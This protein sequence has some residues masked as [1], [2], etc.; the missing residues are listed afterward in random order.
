MFFCFACFQVVESLRPRW[1]FASGYDNDSEGGRHD[2]GR[3]PFSSPEYWS[4]ENDDQESGVEEEEEPVLIVLEEK[5]EAAPIIEAGTEKKKREQQHEKDKK[6]TDA[7]EDESDDGVDSAGAE[8]G[9]SR[10][11]KPRPSRRPKKRG[12]S[13]KRGR[14]ANPLSPQPAVS[15]AAGNTANTAPPLLRT[16]WWEWS[17]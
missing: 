17:D 9:D 10:C 14:L 7:K 6:H 5:K 12:T 15:P 1:N 4:A 2:G 8:D 3:I 11:L 13:K 16:P